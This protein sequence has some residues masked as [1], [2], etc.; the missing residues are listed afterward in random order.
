VSTTPVIPRLWHIPKVGLS[1]GEVVP[2]GRFGRACIAG[3]AGGPL[4]FY[5]ECLIELVRVTR[6][7]PGAV[8]RL[9]CAFA[10]ES[11]EIATALAAHFG[12]PCFEV[13]P[14][15]PSAPISRHDME[16][17]S[18]M[19]RPGTPP[20]GVVE[21][22]ERYWNG[23]PCPAEDVRSQWEWLNSSGLRVVGNA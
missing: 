4:Y 11:R 17:I 2:P 1:I 3:G 18:W 10:F 20:S 9:T 23:L 13:E 15:D 8:S 5:R 7:S 16:W 12:Q 22:I 19:G 21:A 6:A 14:V